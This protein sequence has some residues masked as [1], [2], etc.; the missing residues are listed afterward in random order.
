MAVF[1][2]FGG[3]GNGGGTFAAMSRANMFH[4]HGERAGIVYLSWVPEF[5]KRVRN[6]RAAG[7]LDEHVEVL[8]PYKTLQT[9]V[10][11]QRIRT[12]SSLRAWLRRKSNAVRYKRAG[13]YTV[14]TSRRN[15]T[16]QTPYRIRRFVDSKL[17]SEE[18]FA[19]TGQKTLEFLFDKEK[20]SSI[21]A[22]WPSA[23]KFREFKT[24]AE[25]H[26][27]WMEQ[28]AKD[29]NERSTFICDGPGSARSVS[30]IDRSIANRVFQMHTNQFAEPPYALG[31][32]LKPMYADLMTFA[33]TFDAFVV[34]TEAQARDIRAQFPKLKNIHVIPNIITAEAPESVQK[35][36]EK[37]TMIARLVS[38]KAVDEAIQAFALVHE[39]FPQARL[40]IF[41]E[42]NQ[43]YK[44]ECLVNEL[45]LE[46]VVKL[47]GHTNEPLKEMASSVCTVLPSKYEGS[48]FAIAESLL[49]G[50]PPVSYNCN[51]GP[52]DLI[53][54]GVDGILTP[55][56]NV[57][58]LAAGV[59]ELLT[60]QERAG[61]MGRRGRA[62]I[63]ERYTGDAVHRQW[64][65]LL[66]E[67]DDGFQEN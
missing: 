64:K 67:L 4:R 50:T 60:D 59:S 1:M 14:E 43:R 20:L 11:K 18:H 66:R 24:K 30:K 54:D 22:Y 52:S 5:D 26:I 2:V 57:E 58:A 45:H 41:G 33:H 55:L 65:Y 15:D 21:R 40:E 61:E 35:D 19:N 48:S 56:G 28:L 39:K 47:P 53:D 16:R 23:K 49:A 27:A 17:V 25:W 3:M 29:S 62:K 13:E 9:Y 63:K 51:Y 36:A 46:D 38:S 32:V 6:F 44:L 42:G 10:E 31:N 7:R 8:N 34:L 12:Q 37:V